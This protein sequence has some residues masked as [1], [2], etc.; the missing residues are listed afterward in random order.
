MTAIR[1]LI[2]RHGRSWATKIREIELLLDV[3]SRLT[4]C[5]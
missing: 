1:S 4:I 2:V 3:L 5:A